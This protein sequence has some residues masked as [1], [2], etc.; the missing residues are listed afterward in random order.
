VPTQDDE[1]L[2]ALE[3][4][5]EKELRSVEEEKA[6]K[7]AALKEQRQKEEECRR[8]LEEEQVSTGIATWCTST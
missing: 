1:Y 7:D 6:A 3:A 5:R 4:D 2:A 8:K